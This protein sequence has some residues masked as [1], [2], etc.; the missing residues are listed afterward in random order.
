MIASE[1][2]NARID[3]LAHVCGAFLPLTPVKAGVDRI[4]EVLKNKRDKA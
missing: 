4:A 2:D 3:K 1:E